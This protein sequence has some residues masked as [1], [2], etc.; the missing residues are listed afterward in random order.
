MADPTGRWLNSSQWQC[1]KCAWVNGSAEE[2]CQK[3]G[4]SVRPPEEEPVRA[5]D[6]LDLIGHN[7]ALVDVGPV[8]RA[9]NAVQ[10]LTRVTREKAAALIGK[11]LHAGLKNRGEKGDRAWQAIAEMPEND[12]RAALDSLVGDLEE[13][14]FAIYRISEDEPRP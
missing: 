12:Q 5:P 11:S 9:A 4:E 2:R 14:G 1:P 8:E 7:E 10:A 13:G 6:P 3:C